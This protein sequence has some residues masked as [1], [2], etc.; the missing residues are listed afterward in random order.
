MGKAY[1]DAPC[2]LDPQRTAK[3]NRLTFAFSAARLHLHRCLWFLL[4][5]AITIVAHAS[6]PVASGQG[7]IIVM[8]KNLSPVLLPTTE[9]TRIVG[10]TR[11]TEPIERIPKI[12]EVGD[13]LIGMTGAVTLK[14]RCNNSSILSLSGQFKLRLLRPREDGEC[15]FFYSRKGRSSVDVNAGGPTSI[16]T[17]KSGEIR[18]G[19]RRTRYVVSFAADQPE[20]AQPEVLVFQGQVNFESPSSSGTVNAGEKLI[21]EE[22]SSKKKK[23]DSENFMAAADVS[24][25]LDVSQI[26]NVKNRDAAFRKLR[27]LYLQWLKQINLEAL[28]ELF[29]AQQ[30]LGIPSSQPNSIALKGPLKPGEVRPIDV[31]LS[32][33]GCKNAIKVKLTLIDAP[34]ARLLSSA[35]TVA[36]P[37]ALAKW[38]IQMSANGLPPGSYEGQV[39]I[40]CANCS[41]QMCFLDPLPRA[42]ILDVQ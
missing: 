36:A 14:V 40:T 2:F 41:S 15:N 34:F 18:L 13:E 30:Q 28:M 8:E 25:R 12:L 22:D 39:K 38:T 27:G 5:L 9:V 3:A 7:R 16:Q 24:A 42:L 4:L 21:I 23:L 6:A 31:T 37:G 20:A 11:N 19:S 26:T 1:L 10:A 32:V 35:E 17:G 29:E 33:G